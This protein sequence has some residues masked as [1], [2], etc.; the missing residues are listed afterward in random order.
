MSASPPFAGI[1][2][3]L[4][5]RGSTVLAE[6]SATTGNFQQ[7][8]QAILEKIPPNDSKLTYVYDRYLF[9]YISEGGIVYLCMADD[10]FGRRVPFAF[11]HDMMERFMAAFTHAEIE[12]AITAYSLNS[13]ARSIARQMDYYSRHPQDPIRQVHGEIAQVKDVMVQNIERVLERGDRIDILVDKTN[14]LNNAAF[15]F[16]KRSTALKR[17]YWWRNQKLMLTVAFAVLV[18]IYLLISS[19]CGF[20][21]W[22]KCRA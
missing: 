9:H 3:A 19:M 18:F 20:P 16:R 12:N 4:V 5:A 2:Y 7:V 13:F 1:I 14:S 11:L 21:T 15:A 10:K 6:H 17:Q 22:S 8:T